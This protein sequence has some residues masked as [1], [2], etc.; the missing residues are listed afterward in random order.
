A[1]RSPQLL[2]FLEEIQSAHDLSTTQPTTR[3]SRAPAKLMAGPSAQETSS[4]ELHTTAWL[5]IKP[6]FGRGRGG[7]IKFVVVCNKQQIGCQV[8][9]E[10]KL[11]APNGAGG[12][13]RA[14]RSRAGPDTHAYPRPR[15]LKG[16]A[17]PPN[18]GIPLGQARG[19]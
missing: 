2:R 10:T 9:F 3:R 6:R 14:S 7:L 1:Q 13:A 12:C 18:R 15:L 11:A 16:L 5:Y 4:C 19:V 8:Q 17:R